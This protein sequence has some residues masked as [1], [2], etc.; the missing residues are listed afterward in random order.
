MRGIG[1]GGIIELLF[2]C[3]RTIREAISLIQ[4]EQV[5]IFH[6]SYHFSQEFRAFF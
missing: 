2:C 1:L 6:L 4:V 3:Q 5:E